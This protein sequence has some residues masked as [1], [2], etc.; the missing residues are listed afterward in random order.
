[1]VLY[2]PLAD[3]F[4]IQE[5][6]GMYWLYDNATQFSNAFASCSERLNKLAL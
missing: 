2:R 1:M 4:G 5:K 3:I 6:I